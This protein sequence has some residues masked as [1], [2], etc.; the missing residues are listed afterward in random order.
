MSTGTSPRMRST[1]VKVPDASPG[2]L[3]LNGQQKQFTLEGIWKSPVAPAANMTVDVEVDGGGAITAITVVDTNQIA[4]EKFNQLGGVAQEQGKEAAKL[5]K[6]GIGA[7][8][9]RMG[10][11]ALGAAVVVWIA[12]FLLPSASVNV[13]GPS[14]TSFTFWNL[15]GV[16]F[17]NPQ[18]M[19]AG[20][21]DHGL[22]GFLGFLCI[23]APF[24]APFIKLPWANY[25]NAAPLA[26]FVVGF[27][28]LYMNVSKTF[29]DMV[30][31]GIA[32]PFSWS[33]GLFVLGLATLV[34]AA[35]AMKKPAN[36]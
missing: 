10:A 16:D 24:V 34:L 23:A 4:K 15:L 3:F 30:K 14:A 21:S 11:V 36:A 1:I 22:F 33:W 6:Q 32:S 9:A 2:L 19:L 27:I 8:A 31:A 17:N 7:L 20:G 5:A 29:G 13:G 18:S 28:A 25:L 12:W 26:F 35:G